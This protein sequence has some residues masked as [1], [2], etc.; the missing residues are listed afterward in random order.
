MV[1]LLLLSL[2]GVVA[3]TPVLATEL[4]QNPGFE[5]GQLSPWYPARD[6]CGHGCHEWHVDTQNPHSGTYDVAG[7]GLIELRQ[8]F[9]PTPGSSI[10]NVS[11]WV[12]TGVNN[13]G[14]IDFFYTDNTDEEF[15][16]SANDNQWTF[17][18]ATAEVD[19]SKVLMGFS[20]WGYSFPGAKGSSNGD[21]F[22]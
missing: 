20:V 1:K 2:L 21:Y 14:L 11:F 4:L 22:Y 16:Y 3:V 13:V 19:K 12:I 5:T 6:Y 8:D 10:S 7:D 17:V 9:T 18:D 15:F